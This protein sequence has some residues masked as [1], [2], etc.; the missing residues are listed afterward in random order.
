MHCN[1]LPLPISVGHGSRTRTHGESCGNPYPCLWVWARAGKGTGRGKITH[2]LPVSF[3]TAISSGLSTRL[4]TPASDV[5]AMASIIHPTTAGVD[6]FA[7]G[8]LSQLG[9]SAHMGDHNDCG[10]HVAYEKYK[11]YLEACRVYERK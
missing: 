7:A 9:I 1:L 10:L 11:A 4:P 6:S 2:G 5:A 3:T 8:I